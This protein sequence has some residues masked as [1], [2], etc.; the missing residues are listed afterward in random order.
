MAYS[1]KINKYNTIITVTV[2]FVVQGVSSYP[3]LSQL[4]LN[5]I[6][7]LKIELYSIEEMN[8][9]YITEIKI[10]FSFN[11]LI[12]RQTRY[13]RTE[14]KNEKYI[15]TRHCDDKFLLQKIWREM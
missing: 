1:I 11:E 3:S 12:W 9:F 10:N 8:Q 13:L 7:S 5:L 2:F 15:S 4:P 14:E 6:I